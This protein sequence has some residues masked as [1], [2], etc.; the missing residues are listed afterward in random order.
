MWSWTQTDAATIVFVRK[1]EDWLSE[2]LVGNDAVLR[3]PEIGVEI[4]LADLYF[5]GGGDADGALPTG[6]TSDPSPLVVA[7][8]ITADASALQ[9][10]AYESKNLP[11]RNRLRLH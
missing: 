4:L 9:L 10:A 11:R 7:K 5:V 1:G 2:I 6:S 8:S 3:M